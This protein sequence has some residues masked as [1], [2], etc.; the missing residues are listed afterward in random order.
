MMLLV[1]C[2]LI[3]T[4]LQ[5]C[6]VAYD[7]RNLNIGD[8]LWVARERIQ[9]LPGQFNQPEPKELVLPYIIERKRLGMVRILHT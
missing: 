4:L 2:H 8:F 9:P 1:C 6:G 7:R 3:V 5:S